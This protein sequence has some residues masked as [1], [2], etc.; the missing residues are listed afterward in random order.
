MVELEMDMEMLTASSESCWFPGY[1]WQSAHCG[2]GMPLG[3]RFTAA[4]AGLPI[5]QFWGLKDW[6]VHF[7]ARDMR[8]AS[9]LQCSEEPDEDITD[10]DP[11]EGDDDTSEDEYSDDVD[12][13]D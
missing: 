11:S 12:Y 9:L 1:V 7:S 4:E 10:D 13:E 5:R 3:W 6:V 2:C 8:R